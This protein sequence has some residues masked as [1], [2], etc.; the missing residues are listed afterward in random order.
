MI[1]QSVTLFIWDYQPGEGRGGG[2]VGGDSSQGPRDTQQISSLLRAKPAR[3]Y[4]TQKH[5]ESPFRSC[6]CT[7]RC[8]TLAE[9]STPALELEHN[10][11]LD[12]RNNIS[13]APRNINF[14]RT[15]ISRKNFSSKWWGVARH[16][17]AK[18]W[19]TTKYYFIWSFLLDFL[20]FFNLF[21][22]IY[23]S[24]LYIRHNPKKNLLVINL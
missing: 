10:V 23:A 15:A 14:A 5:A 4:F 18:T 8:C 24:I 17:S 13:Y 6:D 12:D 2:G 11:E 7:H 19:Q 1:L 20:A 22:L 9:K 3:L 21:R 16:C